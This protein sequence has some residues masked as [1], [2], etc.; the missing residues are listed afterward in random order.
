MALERVAQQNARPEAL[1]DGSLVRVIEPPPCP[2]HLGCAVGVSIIEPRG[3]P[4]G[5]VDDLVELER[6]RRLQ[7]AH[8]AEQR[9][10]AYDSR[11]G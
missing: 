11:P 4:P 7:A 9:L 5:V 2:N 6:A 3:E 1:F 8:R 10:E